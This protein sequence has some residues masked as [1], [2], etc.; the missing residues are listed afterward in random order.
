MCLRRLLVP[1]PSPRERGATA[2]MAVVALA[3]SLVVGFGVGFG[4][5]RQAS[6]TTVNLILPSMAP[7][8]SSTSSVPDTTVAPDSTLG[9]ATTAPGT[10]VANTVAVTDPPPPPVTE[11]PLPSISLSTKGALFAAV[12]DRRLFD[13]PG[14][15]DSF[16]ATQQSGDSGGCDQFAVGNIEVAWSID[17][18]A[19]TVDI[20]WRDPA[21]NE[22]DVW[23]V[24]LRAD[25]SGMDHDPRVGDVTG[26]GRSDIVVGR[27]DGATL[28]TDVIELDGAVPAVSLH[29]SLPEGR[30]RL[31]AGE[32]HTWR[33]IEGN[34]DDLE[35]IVLSRGNGGWRVTQGE[36]VK[37]RNVGPSQV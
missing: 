16:T 27:S 28:E 11:P 12:T 26:D 23:N 6:T 25:H 36:T 17:L 30:V 29:L 32:L 20:L 14:G 24:A 19:N 3:V 9:L 4:A 37:A 35:H 18:P 15:C 22:P 21:A 13:A 7:S 1:R 10:T 31:G 34:N 5:R 8:A 2:V 33:A